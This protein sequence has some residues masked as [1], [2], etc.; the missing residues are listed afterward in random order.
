MLRY[1]LSTM[2]ARIPRVIAWRRK[3]QS[4]RRVLVATLLALVLV[5]VGARPVQPRLCFDVPGVANC[6]DGRFQAYWEQ[7]GSL[8]VF[9]YPTSPTAPRQTAE[10]TFETQSFERN[11][12]ELHPET[13]A[14]Y[15]VLLGRLGDERL[16]RLGRDWRTFPKGRQSAECLWFPQTE[17]SVC[18]QEPGIG[19]KTY[20]STHGLDDPRLDAYGKSLALFGLPLGEP[21][22][23]TN[24]A[25]D[26]VLVQWFER[27]R[28]EYHPGQPREFRILLGLL[29]NETEPGI[30][31]PGWNPASF[32]LQTR[33]IARGLERP[34][35][36]TNAGDGSGRLFVVEK[37]GRIRIVVGGEL[38]DVPFLDISDR[39]GSA[40]SE[41]GLFAVAFD[42]GYRDNGL[43][44]VH[45]TDKAGDTVIARYRATPGSNAADPASATT[46]LRIDQPAANHNGGQIAFGPDGYLYIGMGDGGGSGD[47]NRNGQN[48]GTLLG[49]ILRIDVD[50]GNPYGIPP[51][52]PFREVAGARPE[53]WALG[54]RNP[55]RF[56]FDRVTGDLFI[57]DV[58]QNRLEEVHF[59]PG[60]SRGG[61]NYGWNIMEGSACFRPATGCQRSGL[62]LPIAEYSH[63]LGCSI[64]GGFRYRGRDVPA[65][66]DAYFFADYCSGRIWGLA[67][68]GGGWSMT[69]LL[70][71][72]L[73]ISSFGEDERGELYILDAGGGLY[74]LEAQ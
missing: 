42:P 65:F 41:Q 51:D 71:T 67:P 35:H 32:R 34:I 39:V 17:H 73:S 55:W 59:Q 30:A 60:S 12:F 49:K 72:E 38:Q 24:A 47:P 31:P 16:R 8:P 40:G 9:G 54:L 21:A 14:P 58:G 10:G 64:T 62:T 27:A 4:V 68:A 7:N 2:F 1:H 25:G 45:Y 3:E 11:R 44:F 50:G 37:A 26:T 20:W 53:I 66:A 52:N 22:M 57:A 46:L 18:D 43:F 23:E 29:G 13:P 63:D 74:R 61:E 28:F 36:V 70:D 5:P 33:L 48:R 6:V 69:Q 19:F 15:D 56:S